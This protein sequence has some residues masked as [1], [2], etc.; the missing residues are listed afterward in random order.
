MRKKMKKG[1]ECLQALHLPERTSSLISIKIISSHS[2]PLVSIIVFNKLMRSPQKWSIKK[3][4]QV[5]K[6]SVPTYEE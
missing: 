5:A 4:K 3:K 6:K 1:Y 2:C